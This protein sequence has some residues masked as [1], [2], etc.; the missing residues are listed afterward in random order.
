MSA[1][2]NTAAMTREDWLQE[3]RRG[4][5]GSEAAAILGLSPWATPL[6]VYLD[7][8][9]EGEEVEETEAMQMIL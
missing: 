2:I 5:G 7:K 4:I 6:D 1:A 9:G 3:R 8:I